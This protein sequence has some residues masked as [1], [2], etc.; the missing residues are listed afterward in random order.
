MPVVVDSD[1]KDRRESKFLR[2]RIT[3]PKKARG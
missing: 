3:A 1:P 2:E